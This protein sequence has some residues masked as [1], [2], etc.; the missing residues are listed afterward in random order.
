MCGNVDQSG[1]SVISPGNCRWW[2]Y[3]SLP[4]LSYSSCRVR[5]R[6][7]SSNL[8]FTFLFSSRSRSL[9][10]PSWRRCRY[11]WD[12]KCGIVTS[13]PWLL[14][15]IHPRDTQG[16]LSNQSPLKQ[17]GFSYFNS[18][19][20]SKYFG[21]WHPVA[22]SD[23]F[24]RCALRIKAVWLLILTRSSGTFAGRL[25]ATIEPTC[26][27]FGFYHGGRFQKSYLPVPS[28]FKVDRGHGAQRQNHRDSQ[29][30]FRS[31]RHYVRV[32]RR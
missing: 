21:Y 29:D 14:R 5:T 25:T 7:S 16:N 20:Q 30:H 13:S 26:S 17:S 1:S 22:P 4:C 18:I 19:F 8:R 32:S 9:S 2:T 3:V 12:Q 27:L 15:E 10:T 31:S 28:L 24:Y 11:K 23:L 6:C